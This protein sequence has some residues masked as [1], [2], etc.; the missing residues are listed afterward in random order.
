MNI[1]L[2]KC[3]QESDIAELNPV[4]EIEAS[5]R[6]LT[7]GV[8]NGRLERAHKGVTRSI[9]VPFLPPPDETALVDSR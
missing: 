8:R 1:K 9:I 6:I 2:I 3:D 5:S 7:R 4:V